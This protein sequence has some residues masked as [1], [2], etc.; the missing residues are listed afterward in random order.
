M[1]S[2]LSLLACSCLLYSSTLRAQL[3]AEGNNPSSINWRHY[4][5]RAVNFIFPAGLEQQSARAANIINYIHDSLGGTV[6]PK[7]KHLDLLLQTNQVVSNGYVA[8]APFRSEFYATGLQNFNTL[9]SAPWLDLLCFHEYRHALQMPNTRNGLTRF[10][11]ILGGQN[12]WQF[13]QAIS[14]PNW[15]L[16]GDAVQTETLFSGAGRGRTPY[17]FQGQ[18]ALLLGG[19]NYKYIKARNGSFRDFVPDHYPLGYAILQRMRNDKGPDVWAKILHDGSAYRGVFYSFSKA[20]KRY[21]GYS[22]PAAY[23]LAYDSLKTRW[24]GQLAH[25]DMTPTTVISPADSK[26]FTSYQWAHVLPDG[27]IICRKESYKKTATLVLLKNGKETHIR[28][29]GIFTPS[30]SFFSYNNGRLA[31]SEFSTDKRWQNRNYSDIR[32]YDMATRHLRKLTSKTKLFAPQFSAKGDR[33]VAAKADER[34]Q[35]S[36]VFMDAANGKELSSVPNPNNDFIAYPTWT[37]DDKAIVYQ[38][39]RA[40]KI[41]I[42]KYELA[43]GQV[44]ELTPWSQ[45]V[46]GPMTVGKDYVY[47]TA[48]YTGINNIFAVRLNGDKRIKQLSSVKIA[49]AMP[50]LSEDEQTLYMSEFGYM[51]D[52]LTQQHVDAASAREITITEPEAQNDIYQVKT[53]DKEHSIYKQIPAQAFVAQDYRGFIRG[54][55]LHSWGLTGSQ[56]EIGVALAIDNILNDFSAHIQAGYNLNENVPTL[57]GRIDYA[58]YYLPVSLVGNISNR[59]ILSPTNLGDTGVTGTNHTRFTESN[60]GVAVTLPLH[61]VHGIYTRSFVLTGTLGQTITSNQSFNDVDIPNSSQHLTTAEGRLQVTNLRARA[62]QHFNPRF[63]QAL[64][65]YVG[66]SISG[67]SALKYSGEALLYFPGLSANHSL[68]FRG[69]YVKQELSNDYRFLDV[70]NHARGYIAVPGDEEYVVTGNY[71]FPL[72]YPDWGC[73]GLFYLPRLRLN[74]FCDISQVKIKS[75]NKTLDQNSYGFELLLDA[76]LLNV[77]PVTIGLRNAILANRNYYDQDVK[78]QLQFFF[79]GTF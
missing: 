78:N 37:K 8:L 22:T 75:M 18:R 47:F 53:T 56:H 42:L 49:A 9:G 61:W 7:R 13:A 67:A 39:K 34:L 66:S 72:G 50:A 4:N 19:R 30:E 29:L 62:H 70:F 28:T 25:T 64:D 16:E 59:N 74:L 44:T 17:F 24:S 79:A 41:A 40:E 57:T 77:L 48:S 23:A 3:N 51:G 76:K 69:G 2:T 20:M 58:R 46:T 14:I 1:K 26:T 35:N 33:I 63:G 71:Q 6:G 43:S 5:T 21:T 31:W 27:S 68:Y 32:T 65:L 60:Y 52:Q 11:S 38:A 55:K 15:Y 10:V 73:N 54:A 45:Q 36:I 12:L